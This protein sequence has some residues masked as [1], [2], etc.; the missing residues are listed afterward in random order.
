[1]GLGPEPDLTG[2][3]NALPVCVVC[4][5]GDRGDADTA[6]FEL[7]PSKDATTGQHDL[8]MAVVGGDPEE[9]QAWLAS[10]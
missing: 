1:M 6:R 8:A 9:W 10:R 4:P 7:Y 5:G 2:G 3:L